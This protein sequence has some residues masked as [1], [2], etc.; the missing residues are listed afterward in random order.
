VTHSPPRA[1]VERPTT[2]Y[3]NDEEWLTVQTTP[4]DLED[5][6]LGYLC[7]EGVISHPGQLRQVV[8]DDDRGLVWINLAPG[9]EPFPDGRGTAPTYDPVTHDLSITKADALDWMQRML[10]AAVLYHET[11]G[12]HVG[13]AIRTDTGEMIVREDI[14]RHNAIDKVIGALL[15]AKWPTEQ[16]VLLTSG[17][18]SYEMSARLARTGIGIGISRTA[19]TDQA[20]YL[21]SQLGIEL[22]GYARGPRSLTVYTEGKRIVG[23]DTEWS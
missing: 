10:A 16:V 17:R 21:A 2:V 22:V 12:I 11:G 19:A 8:V 5:W 9:V 4:V 14:G 6:V 13:A 18:I 23:R 20:Y 7:G 15:K 1:P 3:L